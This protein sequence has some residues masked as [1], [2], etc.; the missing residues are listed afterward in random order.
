VIDLP[1]D[2]ASAELNAAPF[3]LPVS[4]PADPSAEALDRAREMLAASRRPIA[5]VGGGVVL[6]GAVEE[7]RSFIHAYGIPAVTTLKGLGA[8]DVD[9][10]MLLGM[11]GMHGSRAANEAVQACDLLVCIGA[12]FDDRATGLLSGFAP[13]AHLVH[14][15]VDASEVGKLREAEVGIAGDLRAALRALSDPP[16]VTPD[17]EGWRYVCHESKRP[18][19]AQHNPGGRSVDGPDLLHRL[20]LRAPSPTIVTCDVG[21]HQMWVA[22]HWRVHRPEEHLSSGGLGAMGYGVPAA[23]G[24]RLGRPRARVITVT[25]DGS[26]MM[27]VQELATIARYRLPIQIVVLDNRMLGMVRQ[28]QE[29]FFDRRYSEVDLSDNP[30]FVRLA[31]AFGIPAFRVDRDVEVDGASDRILSSTGPLVCH[32]ALEQATNVWPLVPPGTSN[33]TMLEGAP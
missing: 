16:V 31:E 15:D 11:L 10:P 4:P 13:N 18:R 29:L 28:W 17:T 24:A 14:I 9:D 25:G 22:Q 3:T 32:V 12:R 26:F 8:L 21:Q 7:L 5:Y 19:P 1:K 33:A 2:V 20:S 30:D 6:A 27:N 23:M